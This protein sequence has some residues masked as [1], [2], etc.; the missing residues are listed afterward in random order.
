MAV[1]GGLLWSVVGAEVACLGAIRMNGDNARKPVC[2]N[3]EEFVAVV[4]PLCITVPD[5]CALEVQGQIAILMENHVVPQRA[6]AIGSMSAPKGVSAVGMVKEPER[7]RKGA[8]LAVK[9]KV[10]HVAIISRVG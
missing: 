7:K 2:C 9:P 1:F 5:L 10:D 4:V 8:T 6:S 3:F